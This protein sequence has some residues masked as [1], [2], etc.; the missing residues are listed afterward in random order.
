M[1]QVKAYTG[2]EHAKQRLGALEAPSKDT[3]AGPVRFPARYH[4]EKGFAYITTTA[5]TPAVSWRRETEG[6]RSA[7]TVSL[8]D[9][10]QLRKEGGL[11]WQGKGVVGTVLGW[12][13]CNGMALTTK[14]GNEIHLTAI[15]LRDEMFNRLISIAGHMW[16][17]M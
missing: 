8:A 15:T 14:E 9:I 4:G 17:I 2:G 10:T 11:G 1:N 12:E 3:Y 16:E 5:T 13:V 6:L 7:W